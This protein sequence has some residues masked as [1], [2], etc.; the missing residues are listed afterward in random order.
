MKTFKALIFGCVATALVSSCTVILPV[1]ASRAE[2]GDKKGISTSAVLFGV[3]YLNKDYG[4]KDAAKN[5]NITSA[6]ATV[7]EKTKNMLFFQVKELIV[8]AK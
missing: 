5:G 2:I 8:T 6:I 1:T 4:I 7:D 3:I